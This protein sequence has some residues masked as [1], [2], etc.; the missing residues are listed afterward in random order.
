[1]NR[2][3]IEGNWKQLKGKVIAQWGKLTGNQVDEIEGKSDELSG[4]LQER[5]G[6]AKDAAEEQ[7]ERLDEST[8]K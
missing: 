7:I 8:K 3:S 1:M 4:K 6:D 2:D 5:Y